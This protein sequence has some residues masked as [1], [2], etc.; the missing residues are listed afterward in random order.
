MLLLQ[1]S[2]CGEPGLPVGNRVPPARLRRAEEPACRDRRAVGPTL[3]ASAAAGGGDPRGGDPRGGD[4]RGGDPRGGDTRGG[5]TRGGDTRGGDTRGGTARAGAACPIV[6]VR[7]AAT[8]T[9]AAV[10]YKMH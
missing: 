2:A 6:H 4:P 9:G 5:D 8:A 3:A 10:T 1:A 7:P